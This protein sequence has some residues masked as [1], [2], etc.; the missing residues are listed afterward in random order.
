LNATRSNAIVEAEITDE[1]TLVVGHSL[2]SV[3]AYDVLCNNLSRMKLAGFITIGSPLG[4]TAITSMLGLPTNPAAGPG[5]VNA[6]DLRD[7]VALNPLDANHF[8]AAPP[9]SNFSGV[10]NHTDNRHSIGGYLDDET[11]CYRKRCADPTF[12]NAV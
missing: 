9:I 6:F 7:V 12:L 8:P 10:E 3:V 5:W 1:P 2:G 4:I 11:G